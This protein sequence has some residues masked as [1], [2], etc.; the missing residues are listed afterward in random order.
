MFSLIIFIALNFILEDSTKV[1]Y[2]HWHLTFDNQKMEDLDAKGELVEKIWKNNVRAYT[3]RRIDEGIFEEYYRIN[4]TLFHYKKTLDSLVLEKG[5]FKIETKN[6]VSR[7]TIYISCRYGEYEDILQ[8]YSYYNPIKIDKWKYN[9]SEN[10]SLFGKYDEGKKQGVWRHRKNKEERQ[11]N[12]EMDDTL[13]INYPTTELIH[14]YSD[15][16]IDK[17]FH[18]CTNTLFRGDTLNTR[19]LH[20]SPLHSSEFHKKC[21]DH[22]LLNFLDDQ[23]VEIK[24]NIVKA[25]ISKDLN[26]RYEYT[27]DNESNLIIDLKEFGI[28][29]RKIKYFGQDR[30]K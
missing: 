20:R 18:I 19:L 12:Y 17:E 6:V 29:Q 4:D 9:L 28:I 14:K 7:D 21:D 25:K 13:G 15:W 22:L 16:L 3:K 30:I 2:Y 11:I 5:Y 27:I 23:H 8:F 24:H 10:E 26:G 1:E